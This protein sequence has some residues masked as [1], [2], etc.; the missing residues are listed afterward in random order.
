M[1]MLMIMLILLLLMVQ[2]VLT[3]AKIVSRVTAGLSRAAQRVGIP[4][5]AIDPTRTVLCASVRY[6]LRPRAVPAICCLRQQRAQ[7]AR[8]HDLPT[9]AGK[10]DS[11]SAP[12]CAPR[13]LR[14]PR[15]DRLKAAPAGRTTCCW[16]VCCLLL[17][18]RGKPNSL[19]RGSRREPRATLFV[20][21]ESRGVTAVGVHDWK[22]APHTPYSY[23]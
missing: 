21:S 15:P 4:Y 1:I 11:C 7:N 13:T 2:F 3:D 20:R 17:L 14:R 19:K 10:G 23:K 8:G 9:C 5:P 18:W 6:V 22:F 12:P 16:L